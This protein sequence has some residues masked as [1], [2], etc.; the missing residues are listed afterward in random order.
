[1]PPLG[2]YV[3]GRTAAAGEP[4]QH[5]PLSNKRALPGPTSSRRLQPGHLLP[6]PPVLRQRLPAFPARGSR[7]SAGP[8]LRPDVRLLRLHA[9]ARQPAQ[10]APGDALR[11]AADVPVAP[12]SCRR[13]AEVFP[14]VGRGS[15]VPDAL[16][17]PRDVPAHLRLPPPLDAAVSLRG[18]VNGPEGRE[19]WAPARPRV[20]NVFRAGA[21]GSRNDAEFLAGRAARCTRSR[22]L[23]P[24]RHPPRR[25]FQHLV[26][27]SKGSP[28]D[29]L[30]G[31]SR[32][33]G[34]AGGR[35]LLG[36]APR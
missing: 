15:T 25:R 14:P 17:R 10:P 16:G 12:V 28:G 30:A 34:Y 4:E 3:T 1:M 11:S 21:A 8:R 27:P 29:D 6:F 22:S 36:G 9:V 2:S 19:V 35:G 5:D 18:S 26:S 24:G 33:D 20:G 31:L 7:S 23:L 32:P 13:E